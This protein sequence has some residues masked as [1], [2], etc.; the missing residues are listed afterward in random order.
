MAAEPQKEVPKEALKQE[1]IC[2][3]EEKI[4]YAEQARINKEKAKEAAMRR[5]WIRDKFKYF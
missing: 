3:K 4:P 2:P 1:Q 5:A